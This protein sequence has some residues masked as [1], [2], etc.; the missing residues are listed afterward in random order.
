MAAEYP[1]RREAWLIALSSSW[2]KGATPAGGHWPGRLQLDLVY[3][4]SKHRPSVL[5]EELEA[6]SQLPRLKAS[7]GRVRE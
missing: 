6:R 7:H 3:L 2:H 1:L 4:Q 5:T